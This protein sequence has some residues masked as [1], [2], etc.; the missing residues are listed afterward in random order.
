[1]SQGVCFTC[2]SAPAGNGR[3]GPNSAYCAAC[4]PRDRR[5]AIRTSQAGCGAC[6][7]VF[8][9]VTDFDRGRGPDGCLDPVALGL[10]LAGHVW[11]TREGNAVRATKAARLRPR[12]LP[13]ELGAANGGG[14]VSGEGPDPSGPPGSHWSA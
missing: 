6:G 2:G 1:M 9:T 13:Q 8:A 5:P 12:G 7:R 14:L 11:G 10:E 4:Q 3:A